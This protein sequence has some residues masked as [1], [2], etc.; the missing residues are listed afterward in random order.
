M[1]ASWQARRNAVPTDLPLYGNTR[2]PPSASA[3]LF[4]M[5]NK[6]RKGENN[7]AHRCTHLVST[8]KV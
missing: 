3:L 7:W 4:E 5:G 1:L 2:S 6:L 8:V